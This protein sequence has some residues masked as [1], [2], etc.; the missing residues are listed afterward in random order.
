MSNVQQ[1]ERRKGSWSIMEDQ[2]CKKAV[3]NILKERNHWNTFQRKRE[4]PGGFSWVEVSKRVRTRT[5]KQCRERWMNNLSPFIKKTPW[6]I[7]EDKKLEDIFPEFPRKWAKLAR[8]IEGR[9]PTQVKGRWAYLQRKKLPI[10][11]ANKAYRSYSFPLE[12]QRELEIDFELADE[13][14]ALFKDEVSDGMEKLTK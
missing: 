10:N 13:L 2:M 12:K 14:V 7:E 5:S 8:E 9:T 1:F 11:M 6:T 3:K 4:L